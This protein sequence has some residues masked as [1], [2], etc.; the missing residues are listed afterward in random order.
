MHV[1]MP[2]EL[3]A[4]SLEAALT[5]KDLETSVAWYT[6]ILGFAI[7][8]SH[9][10]GGHLVAVSLRAGAVRLL[11][12]Q[13]DGAKGLD[14]TKGE[15]LSLQITTTQDV[16]AVA[17]SI[18]GRGWALETEPVT[19]PHGLRVFRLRDPDGFR[20]TISSAPAA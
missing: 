14:R 17:A 18:K 16:D 11:L 1:E 2:E 19:G 7:D 13:D 10:R 4:Q 6:G 5:V 12:A 15:G 20:L 3:L 8:R 9:E